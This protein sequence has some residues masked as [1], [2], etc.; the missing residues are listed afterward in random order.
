VGKEITAKLLLL[1][2][3]KIYKSVY[4]LHTTENQKLS[5]FYL[6]QILCKL[7]DFSLCFY[8]ILDN[9]LKGG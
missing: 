3:L 2:I 6:E 9:R 7:R 4:D 1:H 5:K 8:E